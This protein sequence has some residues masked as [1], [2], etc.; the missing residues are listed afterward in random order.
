MVFKTLDSRQ[1]KTAIS[2][3]QE[4]KEVSPTIAPAYCLEKVSRSQY[5]EGELREG[6]EDSLS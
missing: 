5:V 6:A 2:E 3:G 1:I 4:T